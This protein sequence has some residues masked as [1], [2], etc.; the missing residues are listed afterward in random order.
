MKEIDNGGKTRREIDLLD[1]FQTLEIVVAKAASI[2]DM[3]QK[4]KGNYQE[5]HLCREDTRRKALRG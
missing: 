2:K 1:S 4:R 5:C 3:E